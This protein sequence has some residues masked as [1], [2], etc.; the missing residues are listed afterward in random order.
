MAH[1]HLARTIALVTNKGGVGKTSIS[2][3]LAGQLA[4]SGAKV[5]LVDL[6]PQGSQSVILGFHGHPDDDQGWGTVQAIATG[7]PLTVLPG[8]RERLDVVPGGGK[9]KTLIAL[10]YTSGTEDLRGGGVAAAFAQAL[11]ETAA[12][13]RYDFVILDCPPSSNALQD[14]ALAA[15]RYVLVPITTDA[16]S[17]KALEEL[18]PL[19]K[20][21]RAANPELSYLGALI[22]RSHTTTTRLRGATRT[23]LAAFGE[24]VPLFHTFIRDSETYGSDASIKG[25]LAHEV[26][27]ASDHAEAQRLQGL[28]R[29]RADDDDTTSPATPA[30]LSRSAGGVAQDYEDLLRE[31]IQRISSHEQDTTTTTT[32]D[33]A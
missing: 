17:W 22:F 8:I 20:R 25:L 16:L 21:A 1:E 19:V 9:L 14:A 5:L 27:R 10:S 28:R 18:G 3:N 2:A 23:K 4:R 11:D 13:G 7:E 6:D 31:V 15:A 32:E 26:S 33:R 29:R 30:A 24:T 12:T